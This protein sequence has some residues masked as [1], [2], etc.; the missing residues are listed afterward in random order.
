MDLAASTAASIPD[1]PNVRCFGFGVA[2]PT[3]RDGGVISG[4]IKFRAPGVA[5]NGYCY[6][7]TIEDTLAGGDGSVLFEWRPMC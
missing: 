7:F 6:N 3:E 5:R 4:R 1:R 2:S